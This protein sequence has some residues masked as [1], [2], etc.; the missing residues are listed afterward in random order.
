MNSKIETIINDKWK[1]RDEQQKNIGLLDACDFNL[2]NE[3][4]QLN[5]YNTIIKLLFTYSNDNQDS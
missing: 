5:F 2:V 4:R 3:Y 1:A